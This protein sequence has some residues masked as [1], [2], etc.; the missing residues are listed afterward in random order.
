MLKMPRTNPRHAEL[1]ENP[2]GLLVGTGL[3]LAG[4]AALALAL[5]DNAEKA[6]GPK[7]DD[8]FLTQFR[9][10]YEKYNSDTKLDLTASEV[11]AVKA[12]SGIDDVMSPEF[13]K[14]HPNWGKGLSSQDR[15]ATRAHE[16]GLDTDLIARYLSLRFLPRVRD[17]SG[18]SARMTYAE[19]KQ[20]KLKFLAYPYAV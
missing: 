7:V 6:A 13:V 11:A 8:T 4:G 15:I 19:A 5:R 2:A 9:K 16:L 10:A 1:R 17:K 18:K 14:A 20:Q 3:L 12:A